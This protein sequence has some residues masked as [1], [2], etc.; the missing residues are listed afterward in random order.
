MHI[1]LAFCFTHIYRM[2]KDYDESSILLL[3]G[4]YRFHSG[5]LLVCVRYILRTLI[6]ILPTSFE[7]A[8]QSLL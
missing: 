4:T 6:T 5:K 7:S 2:I 3:D 1:I 8:V